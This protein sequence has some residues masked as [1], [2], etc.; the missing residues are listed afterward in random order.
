MTDPRAYVYRPIQREEKIKWGFIAIQN[1][2]IKDG[3]RV[4]FAL[5]EKWSNGEREYGLFAVTYSRQYAEQ[6][7]A[8]GVQMMRGPDL[9]QLLDM[10]DNLMLC[11]VWK[12]S[13]DIDQLELKDAGRRYEMID[14]RAS[15]SEIKEAM[16]RF[17][18]VGEC[19]TEILR[20]WSHLI[21]M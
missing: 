7:L 5:L 2:S 20:E 14:D 16:A 19:H 8:E 3:K 1:S 4:N 17:A 10:N 21:V 6:M 18:A 11:N 12:P 9:Y 15:F 13:Y